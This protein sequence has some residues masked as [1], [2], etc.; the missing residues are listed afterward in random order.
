LDKGSSEYEK[1]NLLIW[2]KKSDSECPLLQDALTKIKNKYPDFVER[3]YPQFDHWHSKAGFVDPKERFNFG[4]IL[5][6]PPAN[7]LEELMGAK[8][9]T[10][11][12][13]RWAYC[14]NL[15]HLFKENR[16]WGK[17]FVNVLLETG[18]EEDFLWSAIADA[19]SETIK[20]EDELGEF[21][22]FLEKQPLKHYIYIAASNFLSKSKFSEDEIKNNKLFDR[23][24]I[25]IK[26]AWNLSLDVDEPLGSDY[27]DWLT[28][29]INHTG[30]KIGKFLVFY[31]DNLYRRKTEKWTGLPKNIQEMII[32]AISG[33]TAIKVYARIAMTQWIGYFFF[34]DKD[35]AI[36]NFLPLFDWGKDRIIAQQTWSTFLKYAGTRSRDLEKFLLPFYRQLAENG[37]ASLKVQSEN[38]EQF[39]SDARESFGMSLSFFP[40]QIIENPQKLKFFYDFLPFL[41]DD[42]RIS[43]A[44][45]MNDFLKNITDEKRRKTWDEW[46]REYVDQ[47]LI[48]IPVALSEGECGAMFNWCL[49]LGDA[50]PE[51]V[52]RIEKMKLSKIRN[53]IYLLVK[54]ILESPLLGKFPIFACRIVNF[55]FQHDQYHHFG[56][57][58]KTLS[59]RF[60]ELIPKTPEFKFFKEHLYEYE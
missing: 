31:C 6:E 52:E 23:A 53:L 14:S 35:F 8:E 47:R 27:G 36:Q 32:D 38:A 3:G 16:D 28:A 12:K 18:H 59:Q 30:G 5:S 44:E 57:E 60:S 19:W 39:D 26:Q 29:A 22:D 50:F 34:W 17:E 37:I 25:F 56:S 15:T 54:N 58:L 2:L 9:N 24:A 40:T 51:M 4:Q 46:L 10:F 20:T 43:L 21:M 48:G 49:H 11:H 7:Y 55:S 42:V 45:G 33:T 41:P 1:F 13:D